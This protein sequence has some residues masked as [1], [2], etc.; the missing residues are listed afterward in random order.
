MERVSE[1][2]LFRAELQQQNIGH[3]RIEINLAVTFLNLSHAEHARKES[4]A[5]SFMQARFAVTSARKSLTR[6]ASGEQREL[7]GGKIRG[8]EAAI[9]HF[10]FSGRGRLA[11]ET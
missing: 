2:E 11:I 3:V 7:L 10:G 4:W 1:S 6:V 9:Q 5:E 8:L